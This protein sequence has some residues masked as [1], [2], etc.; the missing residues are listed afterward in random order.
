MASAEIQMAELAW[1]DN[2]SASERINFWIQALKEDSA[3]I[4]IKI[5]IVCYHKL[6][7]RILLEKLAEER[8][9]VPSSGFAGLQLFQ[10][11]A[12]LNNFVYTSCVE[13]AAKRDIE[14]LE[15]LTSLSNELHG[16]I[17]YSLQTAE[18]DVD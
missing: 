4:V 9:V 17:I 15:L 16:R 11:Q 7:Q 2:G 6:L 10:L 13:V 8:L 5:R 1:R 3:R 18:I 14:R 12:R